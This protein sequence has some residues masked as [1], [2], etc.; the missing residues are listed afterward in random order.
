MVLELEVED[1]GVEEH[2]LLVL[3]LEEG[4]HELVEV[5]V[6]LLLGLPPELLLGVGEVA[7]C[8]GLL[9][10]L[11]VELG[12]EGLDPLPHELLLLEVLLLALGQ[13]DLLDLLLQL[14]LLALHGGEEVGLHAAGRARGGA[15]RVLVF[16]CN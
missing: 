5:E 10:L 15:L 11:R 9:D 6:L 7:V 2:D 12:L 3:A 16:V 14:E 8:L 1:E 13:R 4:L